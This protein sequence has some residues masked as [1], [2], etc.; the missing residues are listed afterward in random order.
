MEKIRLNREEYRDKV[1]GCWLGKNI[2]GT[3]G[4]PFEGQ[5]YTHSL[6]YF[7]WE[8]SRKWL[9][10]ASESWKRAF[11]VTFP[12]DPEKWQPGEPLP[13]DDL[14]FQLVW[15][16]MLEDRGINPTF[17]DFCDY[18]MKHLSKHWYAEY[19]FCTYNL[20]RGLKPPISGAFQNYFVDEMGS[21]IRSEVWACVCPGDPE[22]AASLAWMDSSMDHAGGEGM[23]GEMFWAAV[24][25]A[26]FVIND[27]FTLIDIGLSMIPISSHIAR[28]IK[29]AVRCY[30]DG[31]EWGEARERIATIFGHHNACNAVPNHGFTIIGWLYGKDFGDKLCK[32]VN[33][34]Y[35]T[36]CTGA[37]LGALLGIL[38]GAS[39]IPEE[40]K[41]PVGEK[42]TP[43]PMTVTE[44]LPLT[45]KDLTERV[46]KLAEKMISERS[47]KVEFTEKETSLPK[48]FLSLLFRNEKVRSLLTT[49]I[50]SSIENADGFTIIFHYGGEPVLR[51]RVEKRFEVSIMKGKREIKTEIEIEGPPGWNISKPTFENGRYVFT[52]FTEKV[53]GSNNIK[54]I[55]NLEGKTREITFTILDPE[56]IKL[57]PASTSAPR[58]C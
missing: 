55:I 44:G 42:I 17:K 14:D 28:S 50:H 39:R 51:P 47:D 40:W 7:D 15:V 16:K 30:K 52:I 48:N 6:T 24:E 32:A 26:A 5:K 56:E 41:K 46:Q 2:G 29:E 21:P 4:A 43:V 49:D 57:I 31:L 58:E 8:A 27:P 54:L 53:G 35:D 12:I 20:K 10:W 23:W 38:Y 36:D 37:T 33:C 45:I 11:N 9:R 19:S 13:N 22:L 1:F 34:G 18:W 3:L 25:S